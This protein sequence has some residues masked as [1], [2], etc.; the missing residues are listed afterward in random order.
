VANPNRSAAAALVALLALGACGGPSV[1][2]A[3]ALLRAAQAML[4]ISSVTVDVKYPAGVTFQGYQL[5]SSTSKVKLPSGDSFTTAILK[6][7]A[8]AVSAEVLTLGDKV[9]VRLFSFLPYEPVPDDQRAAYPSPGRMF[10][11]GGGLPA[12]VPH[13]RNPQYQGSER[14]DQNDCQKV[15]A[16]Y[17]AESVGRAVPLLGGKGTVNALL[18]IDNGA[19][20]VR[21]AL[22]TGPFTSS[23]Q[24]VQVEVHLHDFNAAVQIPSPG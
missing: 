21:K 15:A 18:W 24:N 16:T 1:D 7:E 3:T 8:G 5:V 13:G 9:Y 6:T 11:R 17:D 23:G 12:I 22:L 19:F 20:Q 14:V 10:S 4:A 2:A